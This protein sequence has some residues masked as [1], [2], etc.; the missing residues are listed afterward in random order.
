MNQAQ[1]LL[2]GL[3]NIADVKAKSVYLRCRT[4]LADACWVVLLIYALIGGVSALLCAWAIA[5]DWLR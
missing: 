3:Y 2:S 5:W 4:G 1:R